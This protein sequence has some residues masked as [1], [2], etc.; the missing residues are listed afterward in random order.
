M[1]LIATSFDAAKLNCVPRA[2][3]AAL[4]DGQSSPSEVDR[5][6]MMVG[7]SLGPRLPERARGTT[8]RRA[9]AEQTLR[10]VSI[11]SSKASRSLMGDRARRH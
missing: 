9:K 7:F 3:A 10:Q 1:V 5:K 6:L 4:T 11:Q 2:S 8:T